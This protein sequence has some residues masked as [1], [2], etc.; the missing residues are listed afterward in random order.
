MLS[1]YLHWFLLIHRYFLR[2][3]AGCR[4][5]RTRNNTLSSI[6]AY[7][8]GL[9]TLCPL[10]LFDPF[11]LLLLSKLFL[12][13]FLHGFDGLSLILVLWTIAILQTRSI[14]ILICVVCLVDHALGFLRE[15]I[16]FG[17]MI[18]GLCLSL[19]I[20]LY[21]KMRVGRL[22]FG[23]GMWSIDGGDEHS[24]LLSHSLYNIMAASK[25]IVVFIGMIFVTITTVIVYLQQLRYWEVEVS[26]LEHARV[27]V[28]LRVLQD[29]FI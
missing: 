3:P 24:S 1:L 19:S 29:Q 6:C 12:L 25:M 4:L 14:R 13:S 2:P 5:G 22:W 27:D 17:K 20:S 18:L 7:L 11:F 8:L 10:N 26:L 28:V 23:N 16:A 15:Q 9:A 21:S